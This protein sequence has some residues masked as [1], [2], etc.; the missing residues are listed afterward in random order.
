M[1]F[2]VDLI[3]MGSVVAIIVAISGWMYN[4]RKTNMTAG[5]HLAEIEVIQK[6]VSELRGDVKT[7]QSCY[8]TTDG[9][10]IEIKTNLEWFR[11]AINEIKATLEELRNRK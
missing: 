8:Q 3:T 7:M 9:A 10:I 4:I 11:G 6:E 2:Q 1:N 5:K